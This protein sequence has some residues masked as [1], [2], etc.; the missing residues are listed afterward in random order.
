MANI[1]VV[2]NL[3]KK[4]KDKEVLKK[5][6]ITIEEG[7]IIGIIGRNGSG[8]TVLLKILTNLYFPTEG[9]VEYSTYNV[10]DDYGVL[11]DNGFLDDENGFNNLKFLASL[12]GIVKDE[13]IYKILE[14]VRLNPFDKTKYKNYSTGMKQ[15][16]RIAQSIM[17]NP[18][19]LI[20][21]EPFNGLDKD[22]VNYFRNKFLEMNKNGLTIIL[23]SHYH[24]DIEM[25]CSDVYE[26]VDGVLEKI[27]KVKS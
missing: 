5:I 15:K 19:V 20:L 16:L 27:W 7:K 14:F 10:N 13:D 12:K 2:K 23:T 22:S 1:I 25:L 8:K 4:F 18:K 11:I 3:T 21:D 6:N 26:M 9:S 24:E 17:E